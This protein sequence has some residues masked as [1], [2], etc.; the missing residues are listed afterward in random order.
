[1]D[2]LIRVFRTHD[3]VMFDDPEC[4][5]ADS[6]RQASNAPTFG[7]NPRGADAFDDVVRAQ[8]Y[9][10]CALLA[11]ANNPLQPVKEIKYDGDEETRFAFGNVRCVIYPDEGSEQEQLGR[12]RRAASDV[13]RLSVE[14]D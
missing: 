10:F 13:A 7:P 8:G 4:L 5:H 2:E 3:L 9:V 14:G 6:E 1:V 12:L 11:T